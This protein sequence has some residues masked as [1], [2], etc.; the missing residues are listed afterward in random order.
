MFQAVARGIP[1]FG[2]LATKAPVIAAS[3]SAAT[4][5]FPAPTLSPAGV[6]VPGQTLTGGTNLAINGTDPFLG[7]GLVVGDRCLLTGS[8]GGPA[9][10]PGIYTV[11]QLGSGAAP[12][13]LTR[14]TD[15]DTV[16]ELPNGATALSQKAILDGVVYTAYGTY[17][18]DTTGAWALRPSIL[19]ALQVLLSLEVGGGGLLSAP[20]TVFGS[21]IMDE[22]LMDQVNSDTRLYRS[23]AK[24]VTLDDL[25][26]GSLTLL[27]LVAAPIRGKSPTV[28]VF[29]ATG[30]YTVPA[31][32]LYA[33]VECQGSGGAG[34]G[35]AA[36][37]A[38]QGGNGGGGGG[39]GYT[40]KLLLASALTQATYAVTV[41]AAGAVGAAGNNPGGAGGNVTFAGTGLTTVQGT[42]G[43]GGAGQA[44]LA[45]R[46]AVSGGA[47]GGGSGGDYT[48]I[49]E[50]GSNGQVI[51]SAEPLTQ[52]RGGR[53]VLGNGGMPPT[54]SGTG[55]AGTL[56]G[57]GGAGG[58]NSGSQVARQGAA[59]AKGVC[60]V[61]SFFGP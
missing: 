32:L 19:D 37:L 24:T 43:A 1:S 33:E 48:V 56:Y 52:N 4:F 13:I 27:D 44:A 23:A 9:T 7:A 29:A 21:G 26:G 49:G 60:I 54:A 10:S 25:A 58:S 3:D 22:L 40:R 5:P 61:T 11:T 16:A 12:F 41:G 36:T 2:E 18:R 53:S 14:A 6:P 20:L 38:G 35:V 17:V 42:G 31:G 8:G 34:G 39:G 51:A 15:A 28:Q 45:A 57:G 59:G 46:G 55:S 50:D 47:G 30:T